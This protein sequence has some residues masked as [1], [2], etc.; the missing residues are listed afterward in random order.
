[1][2]LTELSEHQKDASLSRH[3][4]EKAR[5]AFVLKKIKK[6][7]PNNDSPVILDIGCGD[8]FVAEGLHDK[9]PNAIIFCVDIAFTDDQM[10]YYSEKYNN[11]NIYVFNSLEN[12]LTKINT[13]ITFVLALDVMEHVENDMAFLR[14]I[15]SIDLFTKDTQFFITVPAFQRL[16]TNHDIILGHYRRYNNKTLEKVTTQ[17][18]LKTV[19]KGYFF[20]SLLLPRFLIKL[21]EMFIKP[22]N[23]TTQ[24]AEWR[25]SAFVT[26]VFKNTLIFDFMLSTFLENFHLKPIGLSNYIICK[27]HV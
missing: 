25:S 15:I 21:K 7:I 24:V 12:A 5:L 16:F 11:K 17:A 9:M 8:T 13:D 4:W 26:S 22:K 6:H 20:T 19:F 3:P 1:M 10:L 23:S 18:G 14:N 2:D 27:K